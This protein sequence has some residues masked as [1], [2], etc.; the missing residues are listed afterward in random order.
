MAFETS[1][2]FGGPAKVSE[3]NLLSYF[4]PGREPT[5]KQERKLSDLFQEFLSSGANTSNIKLAA[6]QL[7]FQYPQ[8][9]AFQEGGSIANELLKRTVLGE[10]KSSKEDI[11]DAN[12]MAQQIWG[13]G[14]NPDEEKWIKKSDLSEQDVAGY[15][16]SSPEA[17][18]A[19]FPSAAEE[20]MAA[21]YGRMRPVRTPSGGLEWRGYG[22]S[23]EP[24]AYTG[25]IG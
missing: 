3:T 7:A 12:F 22:S 10:N 20:R 2:K 5:R 15:M 24:V 8:M 18:L 11:T 23:I 4:G 9:E 25:G 19:G 6:E 1:I 13:R 14:L 16:Y 17:Y 21:Y